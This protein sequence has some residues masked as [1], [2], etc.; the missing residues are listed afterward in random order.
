MQVGIID[1]LHHRPPGRGIDLYGAI[2]RK[3]F[4]GIMP[5]TIAVWCCQLGHQVYYRTYW[6]Q[7]DPLSLLPN[8]I[9]V[10]FV[11]SFTQS[12]ALAYAMATVF[13]RRGTLTVLGGAHARAFP[14]DCARF[15]DIVVKDCDRA[16]IDD[17]MR[18]RFDPPAI[19]SSTRSLTEFPSVE[20]RMPFIKMSAFYGGRVGPTSLVPL[21]SSIG[22]PYECGF[23]VDWN[24]RYITLP[25]DQL[26][27][28]LAFLS[29]RHPNLLIAYQDPNFAV[30]FDSTMD[31]IARI[32]SDRRNRY[33]ME[34]SL[35][36]LKASRL[37][38]LAETNCVYVA[39]GIESWIEYSGKAG[40]GARTGRDKLDAVIAH[41]KLLGQYVPGTQANF[42]FGAD[43]DRGKDPIV[44]TKEFT[45]RMPEVWPSISIP[46]AYGGT[47]LYDQLRRENRV[48]E[49]T[50]F[51]FYYNPYLAIIIKNYDPI[52]YYDKLI[53]LTSAMASSAMMFRR[54]A[55]RT[56]KAFRFVN[57]VRSLSYQPYLR[58]LR[59]IRSTL[60]SD[61]Q[62]LAYHE[63]RSRNL[64]AFYH[65]LFDRLLGRYAELV[66]PAMRRPRLEEAESGLT[67]TRL[68]IAG[69]GTTK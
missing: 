47:P 41:F 38:R 44:L 4:M 10:L 55:T 12:S 22:C 21:L 9:D 52:T 60:G 63:G 34:S 25:Q 36:V 37:P 11:S 69:T 57:A 14:T 3:Q 66:P 67:A 46:T 53:E 2:F 28:D 16:L 45:Q 43:A 65:A 27:A 29:L 17:I 15:F 50:P 20:E 40:T 5:Q 6:G 61:A 64:P 49:A 68:K 1:I 30:R 39:P 35:S 26:I 33:V 19:V 18:R 32:P 58:D 54:L 56:S 62:F 42:I 24:S 7:A 23:C 51:L 13:R 31:L 8:D 59:R 48:L